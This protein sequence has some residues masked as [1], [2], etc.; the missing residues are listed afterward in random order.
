MESTTPL[1]PTELYRIRDTVESILNDKKKYPQ[2]TREHFE[3]KYKDFEREK[4]QLFK[5]AVTSDDAE[6]TLTLIDILAANDDR[7]LE[8]KELAI[9]QAI[10]DRLVNK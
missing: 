8:Q 10:H 2:L 7:T 5:M 3:L 4:P 1:Q 6:L 9:G